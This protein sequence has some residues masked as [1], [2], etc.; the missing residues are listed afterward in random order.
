MR[1]TQITFPGRG[2]G[3]THTLTVLTFGSPGARPHVHVQGG[4][5]ADEGPG[6]MA[7]RMLADRLALAEVEGRVTGCI[8]VL[9]YANPMGLGQ[10]VHGDQDGRFDLYDGRNFNRDYPDL[11]PAAAARLGG[12]LGADAAENTA[13]V[14]QALRAALADA[15]PKGPSDTLRHHLLGLAL[16]ADVVLDL[17]CDGEAEVH[18]YTQAASLDRLMPLA[19]LTGCRA[20]LLADVS[21][22]ESVRR[23]RSPAPGWILRPPSPAIPCPLPAPPARSSC[24][25]VRRVARIRRA[26]CRRACG[27]SDA[28]GRS[29]RGREPAPRHCASRRPWRGPRRCRRRW[30]ALCHTSRTLAHRW[31]R[32]IVGGRYHRSRNRCRH[33]RLTPEPRASSTPAPPPVSPRSPSASARSQAAHRSA[34]AC[35]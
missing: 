5:H 34:T 24:G 29:R 23:G 3:S 12:R 14:R 7:A 33:S 26:G 35:C 18:L 22:G 28:S 31:L 27:L 20:V 4:L 2:P 10:F 32:A 21:G 1:E 17:H 13:L 11:A 9:P 15:T 8:T 19:A 6:M 25:A 16:E 30:R